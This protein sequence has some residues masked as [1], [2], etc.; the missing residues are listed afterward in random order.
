MKNR[1][2]ENAAYVKRYITDW[3]NMLMASK[4]DRDTLLSPIEAEDV[5]NKT[6]ETIKK[7]NLDMVSL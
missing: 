7:L 4:F 3:V 5:R 1:S 2:E 6:W